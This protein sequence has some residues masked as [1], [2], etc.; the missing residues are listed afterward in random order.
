[1]LCQ[2]QM[3]HTE[4]CTSMQQLSWS[5]EIG[6]CQH[7][8]S[9]WVNPFQPFWLCFY[10]LCRAADACSS[11]RAAE[12]ARGDKNHLD[13]HGHEADVQARNYYPGITVNAS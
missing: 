5:K 6:H 9:C 10:G 2:M 13:H 7:V 8:L 12:T 11:S 1:M 4:C 3:Q